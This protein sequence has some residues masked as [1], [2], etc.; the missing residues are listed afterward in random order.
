MSVE[1]TDTPILDVFDGIEA[2]LAT[3]VRGAGDWSKL[4]E[5][6]HRVNLQVNAVPLS[7]LLSLLADFNGLE[8]DEQ[9]R[10]VAPKD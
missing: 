8:R 1:F 6:D 4:V 10:V 2:A 7:V 9:G 3:H 5:N